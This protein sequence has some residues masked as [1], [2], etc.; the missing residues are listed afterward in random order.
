LIYVEGESYSS[1]DILSKE[2]FQ[3]E[4]K[5]HVNWDQISAGEEY[6]TFNEKLDMID[7]RKKPNLSMFDK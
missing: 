7:L 1:P 3:N 5:A 6:V 4:L 2:Q